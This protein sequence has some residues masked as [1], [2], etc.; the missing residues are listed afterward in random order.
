[1]VIAQ[2]VDPGT[3]DPQDHYETPAFNVLLNI[4]ET[5][6]LRD[7]EMKLQPLLATYSKL[8][9]D[10]TWEF[11][12]RKGIKFH[13]GEDFNAAAVKFSLERIADPKNK[14][15]QT[16]LQGII[17][18]VDIIDDY[19]VRVTTSK[20]YPYLD[21]QL[22][23]IGAIMPP[24]H[25]QEKGKGISNS[26]VG[27]GP[28]KFVRWVKDDQLSL[29]ANEQ[30]WRGAP[31]IKKII[32]RPI[33]EATTR[34]A[35]LQTQE[36]DIIVNIP[37]HLSRL[38]DWKGRSAVAKVPSSRVIF[39]GI[40]TTRGGPVA[41]KKVRQAIAQA[42]DLDT[43]IKKVLEGNA[44]KQGVPFTRYHFGYDPN[45]KPLPYDPENAKKL[46][47]EAGYA[48]GFDLT[49]NSPNGRYLN[50][51]EVAEAV[52]GYLRKAGINAS[53]KINEWGTHMTMLYDHKGGPA[54]IL[55]WGGA[56]FD[57]DATLFPML[58]TEQVLSHYSNPKLDAI[59]DE[60]RGIM[61]KNKRQKLY[62]DAS[63]IYRE[64]VPWGFCYQQVDIYGVSE[65]VS[66]KPRPDEKIIVY[67]MSY[68]K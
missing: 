13:N 36:L 50:D 10:N 41:N 34:V 61:D 14:L 24:K 60:A 29:E 17:T 37:P 1:V 11:G 51:K 47:S 45:I 55:G 25:T 35:G 56:T 39:M 32:Y 54:Y 67:N 12:L 59:I 15:K 48:K 62:S 20:P 23:H 21:A 27:T 4:Y 43:I 22:G 6:F 53:V 9:N 2:G 65:R 3:L 52:V 40:D 58:R 49:L 68:K 18:K 31:K 26:P 42:I 8:I 7:D 46:L 33:P 44:I 64:E 30:Y 57:A 66:W 28:F 63:Q 19:T 38:M 16:T 5:L